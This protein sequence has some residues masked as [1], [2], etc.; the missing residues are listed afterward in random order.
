[1][2]DS[3]KYSPKAKKGAGPTKVK[4]P[5]SRDPPP[6]SPQG[7]KRWN[8]PLPDHHSKE[9]PEMASI[10]LLLLAAGCVAAMPLDVPGGNTELHNISSA[11]VPGGVKRSSAAAN[12]TKRNGDAES[13]ADVP[14]GVKRS[15]AAANDTKRNGDAKSSSTAANDAK[16]NGDAESS[17]TAANDAKRN[18]DAESSADVPGGVKR[19]SITNGSRKSRL[20][21]VGKVLDSIFTSDPF[22]WVAE[23]VWSGFTWVSSLGSHLMGF[24][25]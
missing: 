19:S 17:S 6:E 14:G 2:I 8:L 3:H 1:M 16:R 9:Y 7:Y 5:D 10:F 15:S 24:N 4:F 25:F 21:L 23:H 22:V 12:D 11:D 18:G 13:S 20:S